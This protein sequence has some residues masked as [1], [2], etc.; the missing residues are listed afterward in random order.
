MQIV[1][2]VSKLSLLL[3]ESRFLYLLPLLI[4]E[5]LEHLL[6]YDFIGVIVGVMLGYSE[7]LVP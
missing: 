3:D 5:P 7:L 2:N 6:G 4:E 1:Q